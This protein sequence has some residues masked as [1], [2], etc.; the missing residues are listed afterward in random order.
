[1]RLKKYTDYGLRVLI[2]TGSKPEGELSSIKEISETFNI[3]T[4]HVR[5]VVH[6]LNKLEL[7][8]TARGRNGGMFLAKEPEDINIGRVVRMMEND[9]VLLECFDCNTN[10]CVITPS[11]ELRHVVNRAIQAFFQVLDE[12][13]LEDVLD[14]KEELQILMDIT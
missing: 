2:Y 14:N 13:T 12:F 11:C 6:Q 4:E 8:K 3:S 9:F 5:K 1:M 7:I 10:R